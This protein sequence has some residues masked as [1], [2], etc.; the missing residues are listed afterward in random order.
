MNGS[1]ANEPKSKIKSED[2]PVTARLHPL[3]DVFG[4]MLIGFTI[5]ALYSLLTYSPKDPS[6][7][8]RVM[9]SVEVQNN[10]GL[11]GAYLSDLLVQT[12]GT[13]AFV[14]PLITFIIS[15]G[16]IRGKQFDRWPSMLGFGLVF[17][18]VLCGLLTMSFDPDPY[19]GH[20]TVSGGLAGGYVSSYLVLWL[21]AWG[22]RLVLTTLLFIAVM[23][24]VGVPMDTLVRGSGSLFRF[25]LRLLGKGLSRLMALGWALVGLIQEAAKGLWRLA[26][27]V[28]KT[29]QDNRPKLSEPVIVSN[30]AFV[31][32]ELMAP[33]SKQPEPQAGRSRKKKEDDPEEKPQQFAT[34]EDF[35]FVSEGGDYRIPPVDLLEDP[36]RIKNVDKLREE[37]MLNS[38]IL[39]RKL[40]DF[41][42]AGKVVQVLPG[43]VITLYEY[44][45]A[46]GIKVSRILSLTDDLALAMRAPSVRILAP[47]PGKSVVGIE[48]P[49]P[50]RDTVAIKE[51]IQSD[52]FQNTP[53]KLTLA[54]GKDNIGVPMVQDLAQVPHLLIAGSTG[55]GKSVGINSMIISLLLNATPDEVKL[56]MIDPKMLELS[57]YDGIP[58][59]IAPVVT[60]PK[61]AAAALHWA[62]AE[63]ER[64]YKMMAEKSV[65]NITGYNDL[66]EKLDRQRQEEERKNKKTKKK[67]PPVDEETLEDEAFLDTEEEGETEPAVLK[68]LPY[69][70]IIID[71]L[72]DLMMVSSKGVEDSLTRLAQMARAAGIH[73]IV[74]TQRP[75]VDVLTGIIKANFPARL[76]FQVTSRVD[77]RTILD[78][79]G[80]EKLLGKGDMLFLPPGTSRLKRIHGC[81]VSDE[82]INRILK[83]IKDQPKEAEYRADVFEEVVEAEKQRVEEEED[84]DELYDDAVA[85]VAKEKQASISMIQRRLRVG[86]NRAARM[87]EIM[88]REGV[89]GPSDGIKP[90]E[91]YVKPI[92]FD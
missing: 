55:S 71:E 29:M 61:K 65:R 73:L 64:R 82:E 62:V 74:A 56:I 60:N 38:T 25:G 51:I 35:P 44:E 83:F 69:V 80:A 16:L 88:E 30:E 54:V 57:M 2:T 40:A 12:F 9:Q 59:L 67:A 58:H 41:G 31:P 43:P 5:F 84:F 19:F 18:V 85:I 8:S 70:V 81:M 28:R 68:K 45:P 86:Y 24:M 72:A 47:V 7:H 20:V 78:S 48:L 75:S 1:Q 87:I 76:S 50:K 4:V 17:W 53:S 89:V 22:A 91:V 36:V 39:E 66:V 52:I 77:S 49:N 37:I 27:L 23:G 26:R 14:F 10:G 42:I 32:T 6:L 3:R 13:G 34:Q 33:V 92:P 46:P 79:V 21:N 90:R 15:W 11:V 63:M